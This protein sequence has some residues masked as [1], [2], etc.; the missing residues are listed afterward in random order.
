MAGCAKQI[1]SLKL[2]LKLLIGVLRL[3]SQSTFLIFEF[4]SRKTPCCVFH[5]SFEI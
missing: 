2:I 5:K 3:V 1:N 4:C